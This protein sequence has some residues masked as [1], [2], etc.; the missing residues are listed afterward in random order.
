MKWEYRLEKYSMAGFLSKSL[1]ESSVIN[2]LNRL[3]DEGWELITI[4]G[5]NIGFG[6][7]NEII[8]ILKRPKA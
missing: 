2:A 7:T 8:A 3:G 1:D 4:E 5:K 6:E